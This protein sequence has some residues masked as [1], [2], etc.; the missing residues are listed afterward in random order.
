MFYDRIIDAAV[1]MKRFP[2]NFLGD[3]MAHEI[4]HLLLPGKEHFERGI[5]RANVPLNERLQTFDGDQAQIV[6][7]TIKGLSRA[8]IPP[9]SGTR[10]TNQ[11]CMIDMAPNTS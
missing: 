3:V 2:G 5:M 1:T 7:S 9:C 10:R 4:G 8:L 6:R 11:Q